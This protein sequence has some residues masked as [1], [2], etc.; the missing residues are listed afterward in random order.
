MTT[1][2]LHPLRDLLRTSLASKLKK[3]SR[4]AR[5]FAGLEGQLFVLP[6]YKSLPF[7]QEKQL[8]IAE[9]AEIAETSY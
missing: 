8:L 3:Q 9:I 2:S 6:T 1:F 4:M 7:R 5:I